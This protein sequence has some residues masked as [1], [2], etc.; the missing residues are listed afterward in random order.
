MMETDHANGPFFLYT[1]TLTSLYNVS[2]SKQY[3][4]RMSAMKGYLPFRRLQAQC[5]LAVIK[6]KLTSSHDFFIATMRR[7]KP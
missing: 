1:G 4:H 5:L 6:R 7:L 2:E 3:L